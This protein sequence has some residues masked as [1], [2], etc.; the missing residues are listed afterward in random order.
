MGTDRAGVTDT[1]QKIRLAQD[2]PG[3]DEAIPWANDEGAP[4]A[5]VPPPE[6]TFTPASQRRGRGRGSGI[7]FAT[8]RLEDAPNATS[9]ARSFATAAA[10][11]AEGRTA[12]ESGAEDAQAAATNQPGDAAPSATEASSAEPDAGATPAPPEV[13]I[14]TFRV[15][16]RLRLLSKRVAELREDAD[17]EEALNV[18]LR[19]LPEDAR[20]PAAALNMRL[21][22]VPAALREA[23]ALSAPRTFRLPAAVRRELMSEERAASAKAHAKV[24]PSP[25]RRFRLPR[26]LREEMQGSDDAQAAEQPQ[27]P[28]PPVL[29]RAPA[30]VRR[31]LRAEAERKA[32]G[33]PEETALVLRDPSVPPIPPRTAKPTRSVFDTSPDEL[34]LPRRLRRVWREEKQKVLEQ[35]DAEQQ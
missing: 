20:S 33:L 25:T 35:S 17:P 2:G 31:T 21:F 16:A 14:R 13:K 7:P 5:S 18:L 28:R 32:L 29:F 8:P 4:A 22:R 10:A 24:P 12:P 27:A 11:A 23:E 26:E 15:S 6:S 9:D 19:G 3:R 1:S 30:D 34:F